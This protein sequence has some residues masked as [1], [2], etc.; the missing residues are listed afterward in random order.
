MKIKQVEELVGI[1]SKNIRFY[2]DK[3]LVQP[4][5]LENGYRDYRLE[6]VERLKKIKLFRKLGISVETIYK[7]FQNEISINECLENQSMVLKKEQE[8]IEHMYMLTQKMLT[9]SLSIENLDSDYW[10]DEVEKNEKEGVDFMNINKTDIHKKKKLG[11][12]LGAGMM[13][14]FMLLIL[15]VTIYGYL[16]DSQFP[17]WIM[18]LVTIP[19]GVVI[20]GAIVAMGS[21]IKEIDKGE[22]DEAIKY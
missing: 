12:V 3:K 20:V 7:L 21:R 6:D 15:V 17:L 14:V 18:L 22:E 13:L 8:D 5:R 10:L 11:A 9:N 4:K 2:E 19:I 1:T 16:T